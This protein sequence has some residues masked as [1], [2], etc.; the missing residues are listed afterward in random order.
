MH[1]RQLVQ[2]PLQVLVCLCFPLLLQEVLDCLVHGVHVVICSQEV[3]L[4]L[5]D[6]RVQC[7][8]V[9]RDVLHG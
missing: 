3:V 4:E 7:I 6:L 9:A 2:L 8:N 5:V 1:G